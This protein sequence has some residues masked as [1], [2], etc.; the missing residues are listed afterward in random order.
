MGGQSGIHRQ[1]QT[2]STE[3]HVHRGV[4]IKCRCPIPMAVAVLDLA[5]VALIAG[6][7]H[8]LADRMLKVRLSWNSIGSGTELCSAA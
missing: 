8:S 4:P 6:K 5:L 1:A 2:D 3:P 7:A